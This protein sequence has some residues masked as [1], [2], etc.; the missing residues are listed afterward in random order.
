MSQDARG[1]HFYPKGSTNGEN[2]TVKLD[3]SKSETPEAFLRR[4]MQPVANHH[5]CKANQIS[6]GSF[7][8][9]PNIIWTSIAVQVTI[10]ATHTQTRQLYMA[11]RNP[12]TGKV[13]AAIFTNG[14]DVS[15]HTNLE[16]FRYIMDPF[17]FI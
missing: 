4:L 17:A 12:K 8:G 10:K 6:F 1:V 7:N 11:A 5:M 3:N 13:L 15:A 14:P 2:L 9:N 16:D